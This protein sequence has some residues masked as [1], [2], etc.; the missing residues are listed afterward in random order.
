M[1]R[2]LSEGSLL[3]TD[4]NER[5]LSSILTLKEACAASAV[6]EQQA[7][8]FDRNKNLIVPL[9]PM[10]GVMPYHECG[11]GLR[12]GTTRDIA[13]ISRVGKPVC[14][15]IT[16]FSTD[17]SGNPVAL[18]SRRAVQQRCIDHYLGKCVPGDILTG[19]VTH[20]ERFGCFVDVG[21]GIPALLPIDAIS[22]SRIGHPGER[23]QVGQLLRCAVKSVDASGRF[24][25]THRELLGDWEQ[26]AALFTAGETVLGTVRSIE[27][28]GVF[29]EL[30]PNLAGLAEQVEGVE[31]LSE[32]SV[33][34]KSILPDRMKI[35]LVIIDVLPKRNIDP[36]PFHYFFER[37]HIDYFRYSPNCCPRV[38]ETDFS[39]MV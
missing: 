31:L 26:N 13:I 22:V 16:G 34:I 24:L 9:G 35:K 25:L 8:L 5:Y 1:E 20:L 30:T 2:F 39:A 3:L 32:V 33:Y 28:Y 21:C 29:V 12:E 38:I 17:E 37:E 10:K 4:E 14:F 19:R 15:M 11:V 18:L 36:P 7:S 27:S 6:L 23:V